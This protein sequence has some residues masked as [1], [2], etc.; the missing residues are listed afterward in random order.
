MSFYEVADAFNVC[1]TPGVAPPRLPFTELRASGQTTCQDDVVIFN[2]L[3]SCFSVLH[4]IKKNNI[5]TVTL[6]VDYN[7]H[8]AP[9]AET[10]STEDP[11][12]M[13]LLHYNVSPQ[14]KVTRCLLQRRAK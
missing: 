11:D 9:G 3:S 10:Q 4:Q 1:K 14:F 13:C 12:Q 2:P 8:V 6:R 5:I 7:L